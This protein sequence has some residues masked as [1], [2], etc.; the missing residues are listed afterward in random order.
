M[1]SVD[2]EEIGRAMALLANLGWFVEPSSAVAIA[3]LLKLDRVLEPGEVVVVP[4]TGSGL[5][6]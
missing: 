1:L 3:G 6:L 5:K 2:E 4:L